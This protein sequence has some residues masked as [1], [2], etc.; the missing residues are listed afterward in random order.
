MSW[1]NR[2]GDPFICKV[3]LSRFLLL[4][5]TS[6]WRQRRSE[7]SSTAAG[8]RSRIKSSSSQFENKILVLH[9]DGKIIQ[10]LS[11][12]TEDRLAIAISSPHE[13][14]G[15]FLASPAIG[16]GKGITMANSVYDITNEYG[17]TSQVE[18][19]VFD[20]TAS[21]TGVYKGSNTMFEK[22]AGNSFVYE[23]LS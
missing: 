13:I 1:T 17:F 14:P 2:R 4:S 15:Q 19:M 3:L 11:G 20:T 23:P 21:N 9:W 8:I 10:Y 5:T 18:A 22:K 16:D 6:I 7:V 12:K